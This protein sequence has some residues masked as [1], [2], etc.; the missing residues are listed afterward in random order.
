MAERGAPM[1]ARFRS[2]GNKSTEDA[3]VRA[4]RA[5]RLTGW[6]RHVRLPGSPDLVFRAERLAVFVDGCFW[7]GCRRHLRLPTTR[8]DYWPAK[9]E[10][11]RRRDRRV[12]RELR[13][14]GWSVL[15]LWEHQLSGER[16]AHAA[17]RIER[18]LAQRR[19]GFP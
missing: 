17:N 5:A 1:M 4:L 3:L 8:P 13:S 10:R 2:R 9:I 16:A 14:R 6:R 12:A 18:A 15:R 7:H 11:N 19:S